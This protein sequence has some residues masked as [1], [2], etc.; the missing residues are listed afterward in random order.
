VLA[1][2]GERRPELAEQD[3]PDLD[4][5]VAALAASP[6]GAHPVPADLLEGIGAAQFA[7]VLAELRTRLASQARPVLAERAPDA[8]ERRLLADVPPHHGA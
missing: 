4:T 2:S 5:V 7:A 3:A 8:D 6:R 1:I